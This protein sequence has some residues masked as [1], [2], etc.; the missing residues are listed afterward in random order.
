MTAEEPSLLSGE[1]EKLIQKLTTR[2]AL[3]PLAKAI[4]AGRF[5]NSENHSILDLI[6]FAETLGTSPE[7]PFEFFYVSE[8]FQTG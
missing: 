6:P 2:F 4:Y 8:V 1:D 7:D 5:K 3:L